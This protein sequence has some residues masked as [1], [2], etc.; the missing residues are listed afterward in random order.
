MLYLY[1]T[2]RVYLKY[3]KCRFTD[4]TIKKTEKNLRKASNIYYRKIFKK[5]NGTGNP[6][7]NMQSCR[8]ISSAVTLSGHYTCTTDCALCIY[9][10]QA[11]TYLPYHRHRTTKIVM[12][13]RT[14]RRDI[15]KKKRKITYIQLATVYD[16]NS[17]EYTAARCCECNAIES[18]KARGFV[19]TTTRI[20][21]YYFIVRQCCVLKNMYI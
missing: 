3:Q 6:V 17:L 9:T 11:I 8:H 10:R 7:H 1:F 5:K 15:I 21:Y 16:F 12:A 14:E 20:R 2:P 4:E 13:K 18:K 19:Y